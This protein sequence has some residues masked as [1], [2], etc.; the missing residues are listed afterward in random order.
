M[1]EH[2]E[3]N[4]PQPFLCSDITKPYEED[5]IVSRF[6]QVTL[7]FLS[8]PCQPYCR[9][10]RRRRGDS[11]VDVM[12]CGVRIYIRIHPPCIVLENVDNFEKCAWEPVWE[13][14]LR[15]Q[16]EAAGYHVTVLATQQCK[17]WL[18]S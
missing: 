9:A 1:R 11:R 8:G 10:G 2:W 6:T 15:P 14:E 7:G 16:L 18:G 17:A 3:H 4:F 13:E 12:R 5:A